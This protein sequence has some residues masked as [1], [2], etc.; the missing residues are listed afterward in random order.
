MNDPPPYSDIY[1]DVISI[2]ETPL[3]AVQRF[4]VPELLHLTFAHLTLETLSTCMRVSRNWFSIAVEYLWRTVRVKHFLQLTASGRRLTQSVSTPRGPSQYEFRL[5]HAEALRLGIYASHITVLAWMSDEYE[6]SSFHEPYFDFLIDQLIERWCELIHQ[7]P[8]LLPDA[9]RIITLSNLFPRLRAL[10]GS[11]SGSDFPNT[12]E[13]L[14][15]IKPIQGL[16]QP[17]GVIYRSEHTSSLVATTSLELIADATHMP[18][19]Y[20]FELKRNPRLRRLDL[21]RR[22]R[23]PIHDDWDK[24]QAESGWLKE[25]HMPINVKPP[26]RHLTLRSYDVAYLFA[27]LM[28]HR[29]FGPV[30]H[31]RT[32]HLENFGSSRRRA[33][34]VSSSHREGRHSPA[35]GEEEAMIDEP[36][37]DSPISPPG[38]WWDSDSSVGAAPINPPSV[39]SRE[40]SAGPS[41]AAVGLS[42]LEASGGMTSLSDIQP[43]PLTEAALRQMNGTIPDPVPN[44]L[45]SEEPSDTSSDSLPP[46]QQPDANHAGQGPQSDSSG[47]GHGQ[48]DA[49]EQHVGAQTD[50]DS[51]Y[52]ASSEEG[53]LLYPLGFNLF[54]DMFS[55]EESDSEMSWQSSSSS[56]FASVETPNRSFLELIA[57]SCPELETLILEQEWE[58][59]QL[60]SNSSTMFDRPQGRTHGAEVRVSDA[61]RLVLRV[62][63]RAIPDI[64]ERTMVVV[65]GIKTYLK[66]RQQTKKGKGKKVQR[67]L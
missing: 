57:R 65:S 41:R 52:T 19:L 59:D 18:T 35:A 49:S 30:T 22:S 24:I 11:T 28:D 54:N 44:H 38:R 31:I 47:G 5:T 61:N 17:L 15:P 3:A 25:D 66:K 33:M 29:M 67:R 48:S 39:A 6:P 27:K 10:K 64:E 1:E 32:L 34:S 58:W 45:T 14:I 36:D 20:F 7:R 16:L 43:I 62:N 13:F 60:I 9:P 63:F 56:S 53:N 42:G 37:E 50:S 21:S 40:D 51:A 26:L 4:Q 2:N 55:T 8:S 46:P 12:S 23:R